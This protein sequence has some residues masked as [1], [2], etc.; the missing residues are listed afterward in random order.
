LQSRKFEESKKAIKEN[1]WKEAACEL[2][3]I[4]VA[5]CQ[6][7]LQHI[8]YNDWEHTKNEKLINECYNNK[9]IDK[10]F[11]EKLNK[12][13]QILNSIVHENKDVSYNS[14]HFAFKTVEEFLNDYIVVYCD[15]FIEN[16]N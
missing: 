10:Q 9:I 16:K 2:R 11:C 1:Y 13:R 5:N 12:A 7:V 4:I 3:N 15:N 8:T 14:L 6:L